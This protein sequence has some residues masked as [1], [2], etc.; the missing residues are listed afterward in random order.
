MKEKIRDNIDEMFIELLKKDSDYA[1]EKSYEMK[2][3][4]RCAADM[5][6]ITD[7]EVFL[8]LTAMHTVCCELRP[9]KLEQ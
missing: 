2:G 6:Y 9:K 8:L 3:Y 4:I 1:Y 5:G 7:D